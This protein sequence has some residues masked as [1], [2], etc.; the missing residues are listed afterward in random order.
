VKR[1][2]HSSAPQAAPPPASTVETARRRPP[3]DLELSDG[4]VLLRRWRPTD[5]DAL[6]EIW[7]DRELQ[8]RFGVEPPV[9]TG[10]SAAYIEGV[11]ARWRDGLQVSV[12]VTVDGALVGGCDLDHLDTDRPDLG[13]WLAPEARGQGHATRAARLLLDWAA[14]TLGVTDVCIEVEPDNASSIAVAARL[15]FARAEGAA[16]TDGAHSLQVYGLTISR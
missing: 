7:Q 13:Y 3:A 6:A 5:V 14:A 10:S 12:A 15:G 16:R 8:G 2:L 4:V 1:R 11:A 9:T